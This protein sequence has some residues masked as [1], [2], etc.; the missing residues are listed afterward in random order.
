MKIEIK[1]MEVTNKENLIDD[2]ID[3]DVQI[4]ILRRIKAAEA[5]HGVKI[6]H[7]IESGSR[8]WGFES[9]NSDYDV[10][11]IYAHPKDWYLSVN[12]E[13]KRDVIEYPIVDEIDINGWDIRKALKLFWKSNPAFIEWLQSPI[14]YVDDDHFADKARELMP[15]IASSHKGIYHYLHMARGNFR[16]YLK[17]ELVPLKK[18]FY[19]LRP[20]LAIMWL[21]K[22][23]KPAPIEFEILRKLVSDNKPLDEAISYLLVRKRASLEKEYAPAMPVINEFIESQLARLEGYA[24]KAKGKEAGFELLNRL[25]KAVLE[26]N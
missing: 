8:A 7:A 23:D 11:F 18:Y 20:L 16:E 22:Y 21:E 2:R 10:R 17:K 5:E 15:L 9:P 6:L 25:F 13:D 12:L 1:A 24:E 3:K 19:V 4:E 14:V 26:K